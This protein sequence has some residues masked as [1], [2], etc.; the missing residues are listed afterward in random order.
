MA[1][2]RRKHRRKNQK[3]QLGTVSANSVQAFQT[4]YSPRTLGRSAR[5]QIPSHGER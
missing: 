3:N 4:E 5:L 1:C 2:H